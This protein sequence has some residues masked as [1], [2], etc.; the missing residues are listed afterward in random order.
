MSYRPVV[1]HLPPLVDIPF[2]LRH[3]CWFC[4][5]PSNDVFSY[6]AKPSTP[7]PSLTLPACTECSRLAKKHLL[8]SIWDCRDA[9]KD[10]L[11]KIYHKDLAIGINWTEEELA[12]SG[13]DCRILSGF[14]ESAWMMYQIAKGRINAKGW[15]L[16]LNGIDIEQGYQPQFEFD[17][18]SF[19]SLNKAITHYCDTLSL[20]KHLL[21]EL[22]NI[23][24]KEKFAYAIRL[25]RMNI[26]ITREHQ[27]LLLQQVKE[28][29]EQ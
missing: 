14:K 3:Q 16:V 23:V 18:L 17:G 27:K 8:T 11:M 9:V 4:A 2:D 6:Y 24:G 13:F 26:G 19:N 29:F 1:N 12:E 28:E 7:H 25:C 5:E 21:C 10:D 15:P 20:N 22:L